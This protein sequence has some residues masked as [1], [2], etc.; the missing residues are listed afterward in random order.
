MQQANATHPLCC[1]MSAIQRNPEYHLSQELRDR[2]WFLI[3]VACAA[4][5]NKRAL[6]AALKPGRA[7]KLRLSAIFLG[8]LTLYLLKP[9]MQ[10]FLNIL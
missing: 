6:V 3:V 9:E 1:N 10:V 5:L 4:F 8:S 7:R 2:E